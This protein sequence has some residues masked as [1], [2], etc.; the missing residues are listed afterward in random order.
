MI[1]VDTNV[2]VY[3]VENHPKYG[4]SCKRILEDIE[5][6]R[7]EASC[8]I[9]VLVEL[10]N[11]LKK[12]NAILSRQGKK[13]LNI[14]DNMDAVLSLPIAWIDLDLLI[15]ERAS[16]YTYDMNGVDYIHVSSMEINSISEI[17]SADK[18]FDKVSSIRRTDPLYY[19]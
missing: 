18:D 19:S 8:S 5:G 10:I 6:G 15:I 4:Q 14:K 2:F 11:V 17:L 13:K 1:Y 9:L 3:A 7:L 16:S 12:I